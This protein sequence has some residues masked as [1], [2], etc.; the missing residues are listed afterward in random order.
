MP[1]EPHSHRDANVAALN[2]ITRRALAAQD[3]DPRVQVHADGPH[4]SASLRTADGRMVRLHSARNPEREAEQFVESALGN[5][6]GGAPPVVMVIGPG[7]GYVLDVIERRAPGTRII[8]IEPF[9]A[10]ANA[11]LDRRDWRDWIESKRLT[12][13][14][15][16]EYPGAGDVGRLIDERAAEAA[17]IVE[18]PVIAREFPALAAKA[19]QA[20]EHIVRGAKLNAEARR[21]FAGRY[22]LNTLKNL[23]AI[24]EEGDAASLRD[25]FTGVPVVVVAAGPSLDR[26]LDELRRLQEHALIVAVDTTLRPLGAAGIRPHLVVAV[27]PSELNARHLLDLDDVEGSWLV[28][29]GSI[30]PRV[31]PQFQGRVFTFKVSDH[32]PWRWLRTQGVERGT[33]RAWGSV[34]TTAFDLVLSMGCEP[35][36]FVGADLS[37]PG[38]V[39]YCRGTANESPEVQDASDAVRAEGFA[40]AARTHRRATVEAIDVAGQPIASTPQFLQFRDWLVS[41]AA[42]AQPRRIVN[43]TGGGI[44]YGEGIAQGDLASAV[45]DAGALDARERLSAAWRESLAER[46]TAAARITDLLVRREPDVVPYDAW[47]TFAATAAAADGVFAYVDEAWRSAPAIATPPTSALSWPGMTVTFAVE[48]RGGPIPCVQWQVSAD[49]GASWRDV[50]AAT[51]T[52][53]T[54]TVQPADDGLL[55]RAVAANVHGEAVSE[56]A[57]VMLA[58]NVAVADFDGDGRLDVAFRDPVAGTNEIWFLAGHAR[59]KIGQLLTVPHDQWHVAGVAD[60]GATGRRSLLWRDRYG[61]D[62][63]WHLDGLARQRELFEAVDPVWRLVG[64]ADFDGDGRTDL[65]WRHALTGEMTVWYMHGLLPARRGA[66][67]GEPD[68][69]WVVAAVADMDGNGTPDILWR[70]AE[71]GAT[72]VWC[73][74]REGEPAVHMM[75]AEPDLSW[76][77]VGAGDFAGRGHVDLLW[78]HHPSGAFRFWR[79]EG[80][81]RQAIVPLEASAPCETE[82][83]P[84]ELE[85]RG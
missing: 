8:A 6:P 55:F 3:D 12:L 4:P 57:A 61:N 76:Q 45:R 42:E 75:D 30:D 32:E 7:L 53:H 23:P 60:L 17:A 19:R 70:H 10:L 54:F 22:L 15:G 81:E 71:S 46:R 9:P 80:L 84:E 58:S 73:L 11:M 29:E 36:A 85:R 16:P 62:Q 72:R 66:I 13:L 1:T 2:V 51:N 67:V 27:D 65:L 21:H 40:L 25:L 44:L 77:L 24:L 52:T 35:I 48:L 82:V 59:R 69:R 74:G 34:L 79:M 5:L 41:R 18:H 39:H 63:V 38:G 68:L 28:T 31:M 37:Y 43:A 50:P 33:L 83:A 64:A 49:S 47:R 78:R 26:A 56:P 20:A 14:V